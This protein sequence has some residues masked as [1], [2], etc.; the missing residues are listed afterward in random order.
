M[1]SNKKIN[2]TKLVENISYSQTLFLSNPYPYEH[3]LKVSFIANLIS[4]EM[5]LEKSQ[6]IDLYLSSLLHDIGA[7]LSESSYLLE[8]NKRKEINVQNHAYS[9]Y[10][11]LRDIPFFDKIASIIKNHHNENTQNSLSKIILFADEIEVLIRNS[12]FTSTREI[13][14]KAFSIFK[15][16]ASFKDILDAFLSVSKNDY[17]LF[18]LNNVEEV[19]K[20]NSSLIEDRFE[21]L[22]NEQL[23][24]LAKSIAKNLVDAKSEFTKLHSIDVTYTAVSIAKTMGFPPMDCQKIETAGFLHDIGKIFIPY[25][26]LEKPDK[27]T[28]NEWLIMK[29]HVYYTYSFLNTLGLDKEIVDIASF[30]HEN[31]DG[32]GYPFGLTSNDLTIFQRI[33]A[34]AD[35]YAALRQQR[36]Y[37][38]DRLG[39]NDAI[40]IL[41]KMAKAGKID[42]NVVKAIPYNLLMLW[43][44]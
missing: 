21:I 41:E 1:I 37:R 13:Q 3:S 42:I 5:K 34:V 22:S 38:K 26:I 23:G 25:N 29:S 17:F 4:R 7:L 9:G 12:N 6:R 39:H 19:K 31:L 33:M 2:I 11:L 28:E 30:H 24:D 36:P 8:L 35:I 43:E 27:L 14:A 10:E 15:D 40:E 32:S 16:K 44:Y 20:E 18:I